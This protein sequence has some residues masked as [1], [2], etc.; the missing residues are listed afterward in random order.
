MRSQ[1][2][3]TTRFLL[4]PLRSSDQEFI[5]RGLSNTDVIRHYGVSFTT[6]EATRE[7]MD[8]YAG[9]LKNGTGIWWAIMAGEDPVG[10]IGI[11]GIHKVH[12]K[13]EIGFW[14]LPEHWGN[15]IIPEAI[16]PV[17]KYVFKVL[18]LHRIEALVEEGNAASSRVLEKAG[19]QHEGT[20][21]E[22]EVKNGRRIS[23]EI[24]ALLDHA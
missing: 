3:K 4:R 7:Q 18:G 1:E 12:G 14:L 8:W 16:Q 9:L 19:F 2:L 6:Y 5:F 24:W 23:L 22:C 21:R 13:G 15:A 11:N 17:L 10:A 20:M